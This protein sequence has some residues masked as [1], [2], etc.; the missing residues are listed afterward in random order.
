[1]SAPPLLSLRSQVSP[2]RKSIGDCGGKTRGVRVSGWERSGRCA[3]T[4]RGESYTWGLL[5]GVSWYGEGAG[6][7]DVVVVVGGAG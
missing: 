7:D 4:R 2:V 6:K 5:L 1:M 3:E